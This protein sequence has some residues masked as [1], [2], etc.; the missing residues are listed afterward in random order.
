MK[1]MILSAGFGT[2]LAPYTDTLPKALVPYKN[3]PMIS[4]QIERLKKIGVNEIVVNA[5]HFSEK[6]V[7]YFSQNSFDVDGSIIIEEKIL[8]TGGG[9]LNAADQFADEDFFIVVN[10]DVETDMDLERMILHHRSLDP[11]ATIAVQKRKTKRFL[12]FDNEMKL[13][14]RGNE[15]SEIKNL[16]AFNGIHI[17]SNRIFKK[18]FEIEFE[19]IISIYLKVIKD[20]KEF[21]SG[22]N[23]GECS[24]KDL[25]KKENLLS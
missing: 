19:D 17:I 9:I 3:I 23:A 15:N 2:R 13:K 21:V 7:D 6:I 25:G 20:K 24:F 11:F 18:G 16:Y 22:Y 4:Y 10:V 8:G 12:E 14:G 5:H 1:A